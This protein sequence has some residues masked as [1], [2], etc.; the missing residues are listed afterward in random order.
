MHDIPSSGTRPL[1]VDSLFSGYGGLDLAVDHH[2]D[3]E[4]IWYT[5]L[6][7]HVVRVFSHHWPDA[8]N[9]GDIGTIDWSQVPPVDI[10]C[11]GFPCQD[12]STVGKQAGLAAF[13][14]A[15]GATATLRD[16]ESDPW[17]LGV[18]PA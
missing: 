18:E 2:F 5:E 12:V 10:L 4:T 3:A 1:R 16:L 17:G 8:P 15:I 7:E 11:G 13:V 14:D 6:N 9:F